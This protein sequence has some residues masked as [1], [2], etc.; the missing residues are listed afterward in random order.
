MKKIVVISAS[1]RTGKKSDRVA[2]Y[3]TDYISSH[4]IGEA[5]LVDLEAYQFPVFNERLSVLKT[6]PA[7]LVDFAE[8]ISTADGIVLV[9]P[10]YNGGYPASLKNAIDVL[11][12]EWKRKPI[13][14]ATVSAGPFGGMNVITSLQ[15]TLWKIGA[16]TVPVMFPVALV[17]DNFDENGNATDKEKT[18]KLAAAFLAEL[19]WSMEAVSKMK[20]P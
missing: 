4:Q 5:L 8:K 15:F 14:I 11:Y 3:F 6:P 2:K 10:E 12:D 7:G 19:S 16:W 13:V 17:N 20:A 1:V 18:D 9:T